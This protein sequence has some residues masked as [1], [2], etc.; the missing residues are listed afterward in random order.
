[1]SET[2]YT[3]TADIRY[4][5]GTLEG[6]DIPAGHFARGLTH[7]RACSVASFLTKCHTSND[8]MRAAVTGNRYEVTSAASITEEDRV[9]CGRAT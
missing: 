1:M 6:V 3:V 2:T 8:F 5:D 4:L 7:K 9:R